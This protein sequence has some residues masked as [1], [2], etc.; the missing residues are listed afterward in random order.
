M[1]IMRWMIAAGTLLLAV[2]GVYTF[3]AGSASKF[4]CDDVAEEAK[5]IAA[6]NGAPI[7]EINAIEEVSRQYGRGRSARSCR[8]EATFASGETSTLYFKG[9]DADGNVMVSISTSGFGDP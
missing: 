8:G 7:R 3:F 1:K 6:E 2:V 4:R 9:Y 5:R